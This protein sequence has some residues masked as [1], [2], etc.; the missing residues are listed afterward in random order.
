MDFLGGPTLTN[1]HASLTARTVSDPTIQNLNAYSFH[2]YGKSGSALQTSIKTLSGQVNYAHTPSS[3]PLPVV[4]TE[5]AAHT[6]AS[7]DGMQST[8]ESPF[9]ASRLAS[10]LLRVGSAGFT[11]YM[12][13]ARLWLGCLSW[14]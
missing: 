13:K 7:W 6:A 12:F 5:H 1:E 14:S 8:A 11:S 9:E 10:Q 4:I 3:S 2:T